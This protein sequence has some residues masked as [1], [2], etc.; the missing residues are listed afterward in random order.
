MYIRG[1]IVGMVVA[2]QTGQVC[3]QERVEREEKVMEVFH[4][5]SSHDLLG[6]AAE[7]SAPRYR[8]RLSGSPEYQAAAE[9]VAGLLGGWGLRPVMADS[10]WYQWFPNAWTEVLE[11]GKVL[12]RRTGKGTGKGT[13]IR[14]LDFPADF[15]PGANS[16]SGK[17]T[18]EVVYAGFGITAPELGYDDYAGLDVKGKI[19]L[20][21]PGV[22]YT[23]NDPALAAWEPY[24]YHR[25]KFRRAQELGAAGLLYTGLTANPNTSYLEGFVY[26]HIS[27]EVASELTAAAGR[28]FSS[29]KKEITS[30][31]K[32]ASFAT[33]REVSITAKTRHFAG[34]R[35]CNVVAMI[36][37]SDPV[38][39]EEAII[40]GAH[41]DAVGHQGTLFPGAL[42]NASGVADLLGA[43]QALASLPEKPARSVIFV[44]F[45]GEECGLYGSLASTTD[46]WWPREKVLAMINLDMVGNGTGFF[47]QG[48]DSWGGVAAHFIKSNEDFLHRPFRSSENRP[49][50]GRPRSD[51]AVF[52]K[53][54]YPTMNLWTTGTVKPVYYHQPLDD[55]HGLTPEIME[56]AAKLIYLGVLG[57]ANDRTLRPGL[58]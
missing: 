31:L 2:L 45:G 8:G 56:D 55:I 49:S 52:L 24:S 53:A 11:P 34:S 47:L 6:Y 57:A 30:G 1:F 39:K 15:Y 25:Y 46:P 27:E 22:P 23:A 3:A 58:P 9:Y 41:L 38:L 17:V 4:T 29:L 40:V 28:E 13:G 33:G 26:A 36:G 7:L 42:D 20:M 50:Y 44:F 21:E 18:G 12:L 10:S 35:G 54:G 14:K 32:P 37:G 16:A 43:A 5:I 51:G 19:L 48:G